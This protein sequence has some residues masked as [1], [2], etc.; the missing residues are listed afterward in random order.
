MYPFYLGMDLHLK[1][2]YVVL[3]NAEGEVL[4]KQRIQNSEIANYI[5]ENVPKETYAVMEATRNWPFFYDL[6]G[7][8]VDRVELA[9]AK[10]VRSIEAAAVKTD[11][12][13]ATVLA[14]PFKNPNQ[15][16]R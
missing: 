2:T 14:V 12:I 16:E 1:R 7:E 9:H 10:E 6:L 13:E 11:R 3:M 4:D 5:S 8:H 15:R